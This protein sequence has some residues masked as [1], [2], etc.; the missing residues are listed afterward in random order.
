MSEQHWRRW[1]V[2]Q[3]VETGALTMS[4]AARM[5]KLSRRQLQRVV[6]TVRERGRKALLHGNTGRAPVN[7]YDDELR[8]RVVEVYRARFEGFND[9]QFSEELAEREGLVL[10]RSTVRR[11]LR[12]AGIGAARKR[13]PPQHRRRRE[14]RAQAGLMMLWDGSTHAWLEERGPR[15]CLVGAMDDATSELLPGAQ[16]VSAE[17]AVAYLHV[18]QSVA[19]EKGLPWSVYTDQHSIFK[20]NDDHW[21]LEEELRGEQDRTQVGRALGEL[22]IEVIF[23]LSPQAKGRVERLWGTLQDRLVS[24]LR[25]ERVA[26]LEQANATLERFRH[27]FNAR[28]ARGPANPSPAWRPLR[29]RPEQLSRVCSFRY[30]ATVLNDN[31]VRLG[32]LVLD[33]PPGPGQRS[34]A[35]SRVDVHQF[36]DG[37]WRVY[38]RTTLIAT[39]APTE[40]GELRAL[41]VRKR[42]AASKVFRRAALRVRI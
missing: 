27:K 4:Q 17:C 2:V 36:L 26:T 1:D 23:A 15:L 5:L 25:L 7:R 24:Q 13:R 42:P 6:Q 9:Q 38:C 8:R 32:G 29:L 12:G 21:T 30:S 41:H 11:L 33:I 34:Y 39:A 20:R 3:R 19:T 31:T 28:F 10:S 18:L 37:T 14:R 40:L 35:R 22:G 16:F